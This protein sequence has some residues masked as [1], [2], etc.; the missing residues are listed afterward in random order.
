[1][2]EDQD[3]DQKTEEPTGKRLREARDKGQLAVSREVGNWFQFAGIIVTLTVIMPMVGQKILMALR[4]FFELPHQIRVGDQGLQ[5]VLGAVALE[6]GLAVLLIF[7]VLLVASVTG[8]IIQT[9]FFASL[10]PIKPSLGALSPAKGFK[11]IFSAAALFELFKG[12]IKLFV[13]GGAAYM[14][15][16]PF[17]DQM[18]LYVGKDMLGVLEAIT[19]ESFKLLLLIMVI[20][21]IIA[22]TDLIYQRYTHHKS[23]RM[24]KSEVKDEYKQSEGDPMIKRRLARLRMEK[25]RKRMMS[26][27]PKA[28]VVITNPTHYAIAMKYDVGRMN[29]PMVLAKGVDAVA[30]RIRK[31]ASEHNIPLVANPPLARALYKTVEVDQEIPAQHYRAVAEIISYVYKIKRKKT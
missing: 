6:V 3:Q 4:V 17:F 16:R 2:A 20:V 23:L 21:T 5:N 19:H 8:T 9:G 11:Q 24:T 13:V 30:E 31:L 22:V 7:F 25:A 14:L 29:A 12:I 10:D 27:V 28:D 18:A 1:M 26:Q 15:L